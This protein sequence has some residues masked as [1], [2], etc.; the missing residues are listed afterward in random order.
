M[1]LT[2]PAAADGA[3]VTSLPS[4]RFASKHEEEPM[5]ASARFEIRPSADKQF[6][7]NLIAPNNEVILT[8]ETYT[9]KAKAQQ[10]VDSVKAHAPLDDRYQRLTAKDGS[11]YFVLRA[12]NNQVIG[13]SEMYS[14]KQKRDE[15]ID[16]VKRHGPGATVRDLT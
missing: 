5:M 13:N 10:G 12:N 15:G 4:A 2:G 3:D 8:S 6:Y 11:P 9:A 7:F 1:T 14:S 16:A